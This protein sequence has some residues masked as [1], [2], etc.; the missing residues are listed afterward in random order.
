M[1]E[2]VYVAVNSNVFV[3]EIKQEAKHGSMYLP[4]SLDND[5]IFGEVVSVSEGYFDHG[6]FVQ[7]CVQ[8]GDVVAFPKIAGTKI[9]FN[10]IP[11]IRV[12]QSD[13][14][15]KQVLGSYDFCTQND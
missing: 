8:L 4:D 10:N 7:S 2:K 1:E 6:M 14:V 12:M 13:I 5:F 3:K 9:N 11:M 15:A